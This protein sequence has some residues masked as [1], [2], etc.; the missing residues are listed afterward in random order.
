MFHPAHI[1][2]CS[3]V[4]IRQ[5]HGFLG[6]FDVLESGWL[7]FDGKTLTLES[8]RDSSRRIFTDVEQ[9]SL[10]VVSEFNNIAECV[11]RQLFV[12]KL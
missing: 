8:D 6:G 4:I 9:Q 2:G 10:K 3:V 12:L 1:D 7:S 5:R 11:G